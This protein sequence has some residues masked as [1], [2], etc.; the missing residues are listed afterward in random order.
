[1]L[2]RRNLGRKIGGGR[3]AVWWYDFTD[4]RSVE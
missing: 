4:V 1:V 2:E 3:C